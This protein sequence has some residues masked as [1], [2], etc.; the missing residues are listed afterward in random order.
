MSIYDKKLD[1]ADKIAAWRLCMGCGACKWAC[2]NKAI[3][4]KDIIDR[5][6]CP[7]VDE[8]KCEKCGSCAE[9]C[10]GISLEHKK[11][12]KEVVEE[13]KEGW[14]PILALHEAYAADESIRFAGSSGGAVT[15]L[16]L[17]AIEKAGFAGIL[18]IKVSADDPIRNVPTF[19]TS[20]EELLQTTGSRYAPAA[21]CQAF[22]LI[23]NA[24]G[25]CV[26]IG[27][28]CDCAALRKACGMDK[29]LKKNVGLS[30]SI[31][32]AGTPATAG[33]F[34]VLKEMGISNVSELES[35]RYRGNGWPGKVTL[36]EKNGKLHRM[37]Y[38][39]AW[40]K[41]LSK[42]VQLR[43]RLCPD[44]TGEF[45]DISC[46]DPWYRETKGNEIGTSLVLVRTD[47]G[48]EFVDKALDSGIARLDIVAGSV[49]PDSQKSVYRRRQSLWGRMLAMKL[50]TIPVPNYKGFILFEEW[51][52]LPMQEKLR[53]VFG[54]FKRG[55]TRKWFVPSQ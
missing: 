3:T 51:K 4:L 16:S 11:F 27:K 53:S 45:A 1:R 15:A 46:G 32:C 26:F 17:Y 50:L 10:P 13:L 52:K 21:P 12:P 5:G 30:V 7:F 42:Y 22:D 2:P 28:P 36:V 37:E 41:I 14:G 34:A 8:S 43:C 47:I 39:Q 55:I 44:S 19:S 48:R 24:D 33:T 25:P 49:L 20:R 6:I 38:E 35:F 40:G 29:D 54:T 23:K 9:V 31:F 18:H